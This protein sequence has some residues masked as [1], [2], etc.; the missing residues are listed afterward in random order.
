[1]KKYVVLFLLI[2]M[3]MSV[4]PQS[5]PAKE[6]T[7]AV[8]M[9][10]GGTLTTEEKSV[11]EARLARL[12]DGRYTIISGAEVNAYAAKVLREENQKEDCDLQKC[13]TRI[14]AQFNAE[15]LIAFK[16]LRKDETAIVAT[17]VVY[18]V[19]DGRDIL[20]KTADCDHCTVDK[21]E[22]L[23]EQMSR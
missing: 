17:L 10:V 16:P 19:I 8:V 13:Y 23:M 4:L 21:L 15:V 9:P 22:K 1:M 5:A 6:K 11:L 20:R 2:L 3:S 18:D 7:R 14:A 12:F